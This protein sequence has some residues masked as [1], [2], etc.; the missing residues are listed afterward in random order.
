MTYHWNWGVLITATYLGWLL[1]GLAWTLIVSVGAFVIAIAAGAVAGIAR[2]LPFA[3]ARLAAAAYVEV[4]RNVPLLLQLFLWY[5]VLPEALPAGIG[6]FLKR[7]LPLPEVWTAVVGI[8]LFSGA[9]LAEQ[10]RAG[11]EAIGRGQGLAAAATGL[12]LAQS[13]RHVLLPL[14]ARLVL[15]PFTS[16]FLNV[17]K[18][19]SLALTIGVLELTGQSRQVESVT[20][21]GIEAFT[22]ATCCYA[23]IA[24]AVIAAMR[25]V[26]HGLAV[27]GGVGRN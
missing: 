12:S 14:A 10:L 18:N 25:R 7:D 9:R 11:I 5:F 19:S 8:G 26:E 2:T 1:S 13:Y 23:V 16:E 22:A 24:L 4:F 17:V 3:V 27:P 20:F 6:H 21:Q 15:P